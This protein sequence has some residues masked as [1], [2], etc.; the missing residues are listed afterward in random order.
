MLVDTSTDNKLS[1][2]QILLKKPQ[3]Y[4]SYCR[5][6][7]F[8]SWC[9]KKEKPFQLQTTIEAKELYNELEKSNSIDLNELP[10]KIYQLSTICD[11]TIADIS[12]RGK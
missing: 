3:S 2:E 12:S 6:C 4:I 7:E 11:R 1:K 8:T 10:E 9:D 5:N